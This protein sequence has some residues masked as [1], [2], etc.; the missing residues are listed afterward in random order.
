MLVTGGSDIV[1]YV[2]FLVLPH[3][4]DM[5]SVMAGKFECVV[6]PLRTEMRTFVICVFIP[7]CELFLILIHD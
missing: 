6:I 3:S 1:F 7:S 4:C 2:I 5:L